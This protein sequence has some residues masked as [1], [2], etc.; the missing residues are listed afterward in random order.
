MTR[1]AT[2][3]THTAT[4]RTTGG[5]RIVHGRMTSWPL[6]TGTATR[7][8]LPYALRMSRRPQQQTTIQHNGNKELCVHLIC[9]F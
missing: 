6:P 1:T 9:S 8:T 3:T 4:A 5:R 2:A 7:A